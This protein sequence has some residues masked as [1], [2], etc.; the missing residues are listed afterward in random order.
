MVLSTHMVLTK[1][2]VAKEVELARGESLTR[3]LPE[4]VSID[5][6]YWK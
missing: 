6:L 4:L 2:E 1:S 5:K 3:M